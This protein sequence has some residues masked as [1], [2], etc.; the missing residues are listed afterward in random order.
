MES[1]R[2]TED[3]DKWRK[4]VHGVQPTLG[5]KT[6]KTEQIIITHLW[7]CYPIRAR[8]ASSISLDG[9]DRVAPG[10]RR[11]VVVLGEGAESVERVPAAHRPP[12]GT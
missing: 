7:C 11:A 2:M 1:I 5:S 4:Y 10:E 9:V 12:G 6:A 3:R 8:S